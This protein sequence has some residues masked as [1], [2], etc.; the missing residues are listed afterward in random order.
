MTRKI[1]KPGT[2]LNHKTRRCVQI[3]GKIGRSVGAKSTS[4]NKYTLQKV[5]TLN[6]DYI[7]KREK[8]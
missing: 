4:D 8:L 7:Y 1:C 2:I 3:D 6:G 5:T